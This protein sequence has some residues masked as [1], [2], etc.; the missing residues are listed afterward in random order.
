MLS[1]GA[2]LHLV[3]RPLWSLPA[4]T[5]EV[6]TAF[7]FLVFGQLSLV[8]LGR[9]YQMP[10]SQ[11]IWPC[12]RQTP[13]LALEVNTFRHDESQAHEMCGLVHN[14]VLFLTRNANASEMERV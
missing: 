2:I 4:L 3:C 13:S 7:W 10:G 11:L 5:L 6:N 8:G 14:L 12:A 1:W 9:L